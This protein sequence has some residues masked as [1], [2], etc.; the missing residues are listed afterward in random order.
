MNRVYNAFV[1]E[2]TGLGKTTGD[3]LTLIGANANVVANHLSFAAAIGADAAAGG[4][5]AV[6]R[7]RSAD[8]VLVP[9]ALDGQGAFVNIGFSHNIRAHSVLRASGSPDA[10]ASIFLTVPI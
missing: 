1:G 6:V 3:R 5:N 8:R 10:S 2:N 9:G 7:G 4:S